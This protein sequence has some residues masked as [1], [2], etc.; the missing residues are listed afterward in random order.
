MRW[1]KLRKNKEGIYLTRWTAPD[2]RRG[3]ESTK[4][5][6]H[7]EACQILEGWQANP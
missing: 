5:D 7:R 6:S 2:G 4:T 3:W 1:S